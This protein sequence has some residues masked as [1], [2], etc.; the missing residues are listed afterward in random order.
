MLTLTKQLQRFNLLDSLKG[1]AIIAVVLY[2]FGTLEL[3]YSGRFLFFENGILPYGYLGVDIFFVISGFFLIRSLFNKFDNHSFNYWDFILHKLIRLWPLVLIVSAVA[4]ATGFN[5]MLPDDYENLAES[6]V[7]SSF[8]G[9]N[10]LACITTK[11]YW[12]VVNQYKPLMHLWYVGVLVQAYV[13]L[14]FL[15][16]LFIKV[17]RDVK[18]GMW[19]GTVVLTLVSFILFLLPVFSAAWKFYYLPFRLFEI[20][21]G[22][23]LLLSNFNGQIVNNHPL[24]TPKPDAC[25]NNWF[26][27]LLFVLVLFMICSRSV[28]ISQSIMLIIVVL[29]TT[30]LIKS[31]WNLHISSNLNSITS[32]FSVLGRASYSIYIWHQCIIAFLFYSFFYKY[33]IASFPVFLFLTCCFSLLSYRFVE[34]PLERVTRFK[35]RERIVFISCVLTAFVLSFLS[36]WIY[37]HSGVVRDVPELNISKHN[38]QRNM[39]KEYSDRPYKWD[40]DFLN[41]GNLR[42]LC[43]GNSFGRDWANILY[44]YNKQLDISY[45]F[46]SD[47]SLKNKLHRVMDADF[48]FYAMG[49]GYNRVPECVKVNVPPDKL[50]IIGNKNY[51]ES[52]GIIYAKKSSANYF[53]QTVIV[54]QALVQE[55]EEESAIWRTHYVNMLKPVTKADGSV[56]VFTE[57]NKFIS[58]DC[59]HLTEA[60][61]KYYSKI[62]DIEKLLKRNVK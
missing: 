11:N 52:N 8:F 28:F 30:L 62:L 27:A 42:I 36:L 46:Y 37:F 44:E 2:H 45:I 20:T 22:G 32:V 49:P 55:N 7:A 26:A 24:E 56:R 6:V 31:V 48:V 50:Y 57:D 10:V 23:F 3:S 43:L 39:H 40:K 1:F 4:L 60:G 17:C 19:I 29:T 33:E 18:K 21:I 14:P 53:K 15:Y 58:Q 13:V 61:A 51:G 5:L 9:N 54:P 25:T 12:D 59:R 41:N 16:Y 34:K 35:K 38:I 47:N